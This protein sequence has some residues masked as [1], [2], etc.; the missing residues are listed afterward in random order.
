M[1]WSPQIRVLTAVS[2]YHA[3]NDGA[4]TIVPIL[5]PLLRD[6]FS[7]SYT[8]IGIITSAGLFMT[9]VGQ[10]ILGHLAD[11]RN[12]RTMLSIG[13]VLIIVTLPLISQAQGFLSL[14]VLVV[15]LRFAASFFHPI[16]VGWISRVFKTE[17]L[18]WA[19]GVQSGSADI[20]A[21]F[22]IVLTPVVVSLVGWE[23][24]TFFWA[25]VAAIM[26]LMGLLVTRGLV[27]TFVVASVDSVDDVQGSFVS[28]VWVFMRQIRWL[29]PGIVLSGAAWG[30]ILTYLP[31]L[32]DA[33]TNLSLPVIGGLVGLWVAVGSLVS[34]FYGWLC[35]HVGRKQV[36]ILS[37]VLLGVCGVVIISVMSF[38]VL[39]VCVVGLGVAAFLSFPALFSFISEVTDGSRE[40]RSF[41]I[42]FTLTLTGGTVMQFVDGVLADVWG[43][44]APFAI[45]SVLGF[46]LAAVFTLRFHHPYVTAV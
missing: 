18:D 7:L 10:L 22:G 2:L 41:G 16:G 36:L 6:L 19:M 31:L 3:A 11:G 4:L 30:V 5:L 38:W 21:F 20:G 43:I 12:T 25:G 15:L 33:Q 1:S 23:E 14:L 29:L 8:Q 44:W 24:A 27:G 9:L 13:I 46:V 34:F 37:Y 17:R 40:G 26:L 42:V 32:L 45:L 35:D 39:V 28:T